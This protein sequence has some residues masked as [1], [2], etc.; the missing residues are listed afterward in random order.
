MYSYLDVNYCE[1]DKCKNRGIK[2]Y[3]LVLYSKMNP[4]IKPLNMQKINDSLLKMINNKNPKV[5]YIASETDKERK[6]FNKTR[7]Y[8]ELLGIN[9]IL[10]FDLEDEYNVNLKKNRLKVMSYI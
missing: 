5:G 3:K 6:Y 9:N 10:Y 7:K 4:E 2:M 1:L 8:Y